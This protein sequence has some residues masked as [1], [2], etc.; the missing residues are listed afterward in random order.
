MLTPFKTLPIHFV[1]LTVVKIGIV[2]V[3]HMGKLKLRVV[4]KCPGS[5]GS[6]CHIQD[7]KLNWILKPGF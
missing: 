4:K 6:K 7:L 3:F 1:I 5:R 2:S